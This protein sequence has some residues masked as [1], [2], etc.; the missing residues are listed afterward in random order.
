MNLRPSWLTNVSVVVTAGLAVFAASLAIGATGTTM[1]EAGVSIED[2][3]SAGTSAKAV[4]A[5]DGLG[6]EGREAAW[7]FLLFELPYLT[8]FGI[9]LSAGCAIAAARLDRSGPPALARAAHAAIPLGFLAAVCDLAQ[10]LG[11]AAI[12]LDSTRQPAPR[13]AELGGALTWVFGLAAGAAFVVGMA[14][15]LRRDSRTA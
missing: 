3:Q 7:W 12:L 8:G 10:N 6:S 11:V 1:A 5:H 15:S 14:V 13:I 4:A 2:L 9:L